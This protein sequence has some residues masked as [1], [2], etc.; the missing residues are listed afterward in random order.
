MRHSDFRI[1]M[2]TR[3]RTNQ[4]IVQIM[5]NKTSSV[6]GYI[7]VREVWPDVGVYT[8]VSPTRELQPLVAL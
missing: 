7:Y 5:G 2:P 1:L 6:V 4:Y 3:V 8:M